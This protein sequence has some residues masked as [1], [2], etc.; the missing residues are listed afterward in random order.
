M[1]L[2]AKHP[3]I[4]KN[5]AGCQ[6]LQQNAIIVTLGTLINAK[7]L[8]INQKWNPLMSDRLRE[9]VMDA[10]L[11]QQEKQKSLAIAKILITI[12]IYLISAGTLMAY[13]TI[14]A[15]LKIIGFMLTGHAF[16][17]LWKSSQN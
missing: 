5:N 9:I 11:Q 2:N 14:P 1:S 10:D 8:N 12:A 13:V 3:V 4:S 15:V 6:S 17:F 7:S 16:F